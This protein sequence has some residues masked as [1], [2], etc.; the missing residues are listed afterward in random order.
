M[1]RRHILGNWRDVAERVLIHWTVTFE[2]ADHTGAQHQLMIYTC[3]PFRPVENFPMDSSR[4]ETHTKSNT[5]Y[6]P[7]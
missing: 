4:I 7:T 3:V 5:T 6:I 2:H 1:L